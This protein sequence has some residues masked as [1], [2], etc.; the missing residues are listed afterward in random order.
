MTH[1]IGTKLKITES[2]FLFRW[3]TQE[4][5]EPTMTATGYKVIVMTNKEL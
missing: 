5:I 1:T 2:F 4:R 3:N